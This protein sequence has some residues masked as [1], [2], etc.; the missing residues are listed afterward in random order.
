MTKQKMRAVLSFIIPAYNAEATLGRTLDTL[1]AQTRD[2]WEAIVVDDG[3][4][5]GTLGLAETYALRDARVRVMSVQTT[6]GVCRA[7]NAGLSLSTSE[8]VCF[9][10][11]DDW[12][13]KDFVKAMVLDDPAIAAA[14]CGYIRVMPDGTPLGKY[15]DRRLQTE[16]FSLLARLCPV[17]IHSVVMRRALV[18]SLGGFDAQVQVCEDWDLWQRAARCGAAFKAVP[19]YLA[20]YRQGE[21]TLSTKNGA[22][23]RDGL[24]V[25]RRGLAADPRLTSPVL[26]HAA[27]L[28][29]GSFPAQASNFAAWCAAAEV[30]AGGDGAALLKWVTGDFSIL[31]WE[32]D[33]AHSVVDGLSVGSKVPKEHLAARFAALEP[34]LRELAEALWRLGQG[35][36]VS[37]SLMS[38]IERAL[39][40]C[41]A[42]PG[43]AI[44]GGTARLDVRLGR[45]SAETFPGRV[46]R[47]Y[48][49]LSRRRRWGLSV[50]LGVQGRLSPREVAE[51]A[52]N[53]MGPARFVL[54]SAA[55]RHPSFWARTAASIG[56]R[57]VRLGIT[58]LIRKSRPRFSPLAELRRAVVPSAV[59]SCS[60]ESSAALAEWAQR[61]RA[62][63]GSAR[64]SEN[65]PV[66]TQAPPQIDV[67]GAQS[68]QS[69]WEQVFAEPDP[70]NYSSDYESRKYERTLEMIAQFAPARALELAC[71]EG[72]FT[73][74]FST[75]VEHL[76]A[77]DI[78]ATALARAKARCACRPN[79]EF[80]QIDLVRGEIPQGMDLITCSEVL[81]YLE[82]VEELSAVLRRLRDALP[83]GGRL[84]MAN[85]FLLRDDKSRTGFDWD[86]KYGA[87]VIHERALALDGWALEQSW[88]TE[89][90]RIDCFR[91]LAE[92]ENVVA[93]AEARALALDC[94][95]DRRLSRYIVWEGAQ[96]R[97]REVQ[98]EVCWRVPVLAY[99]RVAD[100]GPQALRQWRVTPEQFKSQIRWLRS[101]GYHSISATQFIDQRESGRPFR[102]R[103]VLITFDDGYQDFA[104]QAWPVLADSDLGAE[105]FIVAGKT[106]HFSDW[107]SAAGAPASLMNWDTLRT[108]HQE[109]VR[110]GSHLWSHR[111]ATALTNDELMEELV[112]SKAA[113]EQAL[114]TDIGVLAAPY[115]AVDERLSQFAKAAGYRLDFSCAYGKADLRMDGFHA[116]RIEVN[117]HWNVAEFA[118]H[119]QR[120]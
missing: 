11:A 84:V 68:K 67:Q 52:A 12:I 90:Y 46:E 71:A 2:D 102:G 32:A 33:I 31:G 64:S 9:L 119:L 35:P 78:S 99:H 65:G 28:P 45:M 100:D 57:I 1:L 24:T 34:R 5:D 16:G 41:S 4:T 10:D 85:H 62:T 48:V 91:K 30:G 17:A 77:A 61:L 80:R 51:A 75:R 106:G 49:K 92:G 44:L 3:S 6:G 94:V 39:L 72:L 38:Q 42:E 87:K 15:L 20:F 63:H 56:S 37:R 66:A 26:E 19:R 114:S 69:V 60:P 118:R 36:D 59:A 25:L 101:N 98:R 40:E 55:W 14:Y 82:S 79:V 70:W 107:D 115:G 104:E 89:L 88:V 83:P 97:R 112:R 116:P 86:Q 18:A 21:G 95:L 47:V 50:S 43:S 110:F 7:R 54:A 109:G 58:P 13:D 96:A 74:R 73:E 120:P 76:I 27:G 29:A 113:L 103:P 105:V 8:W 111:P 117:G 81:Y 93:P 108:L 22:M 23:L 53:Q